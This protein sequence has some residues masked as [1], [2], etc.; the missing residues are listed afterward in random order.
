MAEID[1]PQMRREEA[2]REDVQGEME[3]GEAMEYELDAA[4]QLQ[5]RLAAEKADKAM[6]EEGED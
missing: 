3:E 2:P 6:M 1:R 5:G 4:A